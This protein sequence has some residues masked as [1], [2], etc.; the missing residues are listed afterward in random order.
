MNSQSLI[1]SVS[2]TIVL[3]MKST[4]SYVYHRLGT[5][6]GKESYRLSMKECINYAS[7]GLE[8]IEMIKAKI[9]GHRSEAQHLYPTKLFNKRV[10]EYRCH[11]MA[12]DQALDI[13]NSLQGRFITGQYDLEPRGFRGKGIIYYEDK[14]IFG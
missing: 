8:S 12:I 4:G 9:E 3:L 14:S 5:Q 6:E 2:E 10:E 13:V 11:H 7:S 1:L